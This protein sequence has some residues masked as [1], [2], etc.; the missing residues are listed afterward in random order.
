MKL[1]YKTETY[2]KKAKKF[3]G[4]IFWHFFFPGE[5]KSLVLFRF[6]KGCI[7]PPKGQACSS[8]IWHG[9]PVF[10]PTTSPLL[11]SSSNI[12]KQKGCLY[13]RSHQNLH[14][15]AVGPAVHHPDPSSAGKG[16]WSQLHRCH[17]QRFSLVSHLCMLLRLRRSTLPRMTQ[18]WGWPTSRTQMRSWGLALWA[19]PDSE[20][21]VHPLSRPPGRVSSG[22]CWH[23][24]FPLFNSASFP[25][26]SFPSTIV[27]L[28]SIP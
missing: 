12:Q 10:S 20:L 5:G 13:L 4:Y 21:K 1:I 24:I 23:C 18:P 27:D 16:L 6:S 15:P 14:T 2:S 26:S 7:W 17:E 11:A 19:Q 28:K 9:F 22:F 3:C 8:L 25:S